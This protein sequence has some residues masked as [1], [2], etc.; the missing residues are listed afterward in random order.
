MK[1]KQN[2]KQQGF[3]LVEI[4]IVLVIIGL[5]LGG[6]LKGRE[7]IQNA[8]VSNLEKSVKEISAALYTYQ[9]RFKALPGDDSKADKHLS[10]LAA[11]DNGDGNGAIS[12]A[13]NSTTDTDES[14]KFWKHLRAA[15]IISGSG[16]DQPTHSFGGIM[17]IYTSTPYGLRYGPTLCFYSLRGD[18]AL[19]LDTRLDDGLPNTGIVRGHATQT[20]YV[21]N[22]NY[23]VC[24]SL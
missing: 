20:D 10:S 22:S 6:V 19:Q 5:M 23:H 9:D 16:S 17:G 24:T 4:A 2:V 15:G 7:L 13:W 12:G 8:K 11:S 3:T 18:I 21:E 14:R 1:I